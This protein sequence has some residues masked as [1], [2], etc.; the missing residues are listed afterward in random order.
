MVAGQRHRRPKRHPSLGAKNFQKKNS[1]FF[2]A[3][4]E[5]F[6]SAI[7]QRPP[8]LFNVFFCPISFLFIFGLAPNEWGP[9]V[10]FWVS[11]FLGAIKS[12]CCCCFGIGSPAVGRRFYWSVRFFF[13]CFVF[14]LVFF[15]FRFFPATVVSLL[16]PKEKKKKKRKK[17]QRKKKRGNNG[18]DSV[19]G[20]D[21]DFVLNVFFLFQNET[22]FFDRLSSPTLAVGCRS[23][24]VFMLSCVSERSRISGRRTSFWFFF[25]FVCLANVASANQKRE[26]EFFFDRREKVYLVLLGFT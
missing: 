12:C 15:F 21:F 11:I 25:L 19:S 13:F 7:H 4:V 9:Y 10:E 3:D 5:E 20:V 17:R 18:E 24:F 6:H 8:F 26:K 14:G 23:S 16:P 1:F 2:F 22:S